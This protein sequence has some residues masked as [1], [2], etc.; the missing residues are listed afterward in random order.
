M[1]E[2]VS[3]QRQNDA[4]SAQLESRLVVG[5]KTIGVLPKFSAASFLIV[6]VVVAIVVAGFC[7]H[8]DH[9]SR[10][11]NVVMKKFE[12]LKY[13]ILRDLVPCPLCNREHLKRKG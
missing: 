8:L 9:R 4:F 1:L 11:G 12:R 3:T 5:K 10:T 7:A 13:M 2:P 6:A